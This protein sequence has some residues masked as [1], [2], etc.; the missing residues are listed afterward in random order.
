MLLDLFV[1]GG[2]VGGVFR[3]YGR[4][5][6]EFDPKY[7]PLAKLVCFK[8]IVILLFF[9]D[10]IFGFLNSKLFKPTATLTFD[11]LYFG[12]P[13]LL[14]A[15]EAT[16]FS[17]TFHWAFRSRLYHEDY[18]PGEPRMSTFRAIFDALN[19]SDIVRATIRA[20]G[21]LFVSGSGAVQLGGSGF[22]SR[23][24]QRTTQLDNM[25]RE[26]LTQQRSAYDH[27]Y[28]PSDGSI[29]YEAPGYPPPASMQQY[30]LG[31]PPNYQRQR[32]SYDQG[33]YGYSSV[34]GRD[35]SPGPDY[36]RMP[37]APRDVV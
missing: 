4:L 31:V 16:I 30:S 7:H 25:G 35:P 6:K 18:R 17:F 34:G 22:K 21:L 12:M 32:D 33:K 26:P 5:K 23:G 13:L 2:A 27:G 19:L 3:F 11:D 37:L 15:I 10:I 1:I 28:T 29:R 20:F 36:D 8:G 24:R 9:Q 14:T